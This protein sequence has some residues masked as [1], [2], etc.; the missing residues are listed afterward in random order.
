M[1][2]S[3]PHVHPIVHGKK[4]KRVEFGAKLGLSLFDG[5]LTHQTI[6]W[7]AYNEGGDL[8]GQAETYRLL[9][10]RYPELI[11]CDKIY[12]TNDNRSWCREH[13]IRV[14]GCSKRAQP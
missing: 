10:G 11:Q 12:H 3:Q 14:G 1:S 6:S 8:S 5:Y 4:G 9:T 13:G 7:D 2:I